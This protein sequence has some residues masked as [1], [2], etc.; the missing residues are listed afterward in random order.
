MNEQV[1]E[2]NDLKSSLALMRNSQTLMRTVQLD[3]FAELTVLKAQFE[4]QSAKFEH[5]SITIIS[6]WVAI[7]GFALVLNFAIVLSK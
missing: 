4:Q 6:K 7:C 5:E 2:T 3:L 1:K